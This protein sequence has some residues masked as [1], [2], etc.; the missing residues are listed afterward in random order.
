MKHALAFGE[1]L[2]KPGSL[3]ELLTPKEKIFAA[4]GA[5]PILVDPV[6]VLEQHPLVERQRRLMAAA[7][8]VDERQGE[9]QRKNRY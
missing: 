4:S 8:V 9:I 6:V 2:F 3:F 5:P 1:E 7:A